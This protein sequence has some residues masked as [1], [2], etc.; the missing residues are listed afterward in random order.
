MP[1]VNSWTR[2]GVG[3]LVIFVHMSAQAPTKEYIRLGGRVIAIENPP[4]PAV[5]VSVLPSAAT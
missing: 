2:S 3:L 4:V 5:T 1:I